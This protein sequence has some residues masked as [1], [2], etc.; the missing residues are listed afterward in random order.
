MM[1]RADDSTEHTIQRYRDPVRLWGGFFL[2]LY[3]VR[4][5]RSYL[6]LLACIGVG[7]AIDCILAILPLVAA[8]NEFGSVIG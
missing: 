3:R 2:I 7:C 4:T 5:R 6:L 1:E 8:S